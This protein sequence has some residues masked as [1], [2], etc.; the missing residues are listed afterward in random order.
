MLRAGGQPEA[1][2]QQR[3]APHGFVAREAQHEGAQH[4]CRFAQNL[5]LF[6]LN[7]ELTSEA[8]DGCRLSLSPHAEFVAS[9]VFRP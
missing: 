4:Q 6:A 3:H 1:R 2:P 8:P 7:L 9:E 5:E